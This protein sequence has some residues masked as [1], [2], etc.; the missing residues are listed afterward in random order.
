VWTSFVQN[1]IQF[2]EYLREQGIANKK[3]YGEIPIE[4]EKT[5]AEEETREKI[6]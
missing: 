3:L 4:N 2:S 1:I 5:L 6:H